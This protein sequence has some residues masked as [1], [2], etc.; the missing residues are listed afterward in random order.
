LISTEFLLTAMVVVLVPGTGVI[1]TVSTGLL[2]GG[3]ASIAAA[4]GCTLGIVPHLVAS[5][6]GLS[7]ILHYSALVFQAFKYAGALYLLFL[8]WSMWREAGTIAVDAETPQP[9]SGYWKTALRG[10]TLNILNPKLSIFFLAFLP[11]FVEAQGPSPGTAP[12]KQML[13]L[14]LIFMAMTLVVFILYG[15]CAHGARTYVI[16]APSRM[17]RIQRSFAAVLA[18]LGLKLAL[19]KA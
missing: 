14:S 19:A 16:G 12:L 8:A 7:A 5:S 10:V 3:R 4:V 15:L 11:L 13:L 9:R 18:A 6:L 2:Q 1:Y 17:R